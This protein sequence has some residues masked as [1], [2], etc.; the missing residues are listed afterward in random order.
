[1]S[2]FIGQYDLLETQLF[3]NHQLPHFIL[4]TK[5]H[6]RDLNRKATLKILSKILSSE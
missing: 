6:I 2:L 5:Q 3:G 1:M 4:G